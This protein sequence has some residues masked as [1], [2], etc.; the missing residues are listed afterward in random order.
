[1]SFNH[2]L[3]LHGD[4]IV[5]SASCPFHEEHSSEASLGVNIITRRYLCTA[6]GAEGEVN[7]D[8]DSIC[9]NSEVTL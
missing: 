9:Q 7:E 8:F 2:K 6:C 5:K 3:V 1:M 4:G